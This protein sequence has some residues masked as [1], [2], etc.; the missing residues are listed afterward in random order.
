MANKSTETHELKA[1]FVPVEF[2]RTLGA[3]LRPPMSEGWK[4]DDIDGQLLSLHR[5]EDTLL[6][7]V[8]F[9]PGSD[10]LRAFD[11]ARPRGILG[12]EVTV[13][14]NVEATVEFAL[15]QRGSG[16]V[17]KPD[18]YF[19]RIV[20][21]NPEQF[22]NLSGAYQGEPW[23]LLSD[24]PGRQHVPAYGRTV[25]R[26][27]AGRGENV[28]FHCRATFVNRIQVFVEFFLH[29]Y[30]KKSAWLNK[31]KELVIELPNSLWIAQL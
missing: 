1:A 7:S 3:D 15:T 17:F 28:P 16:S 24:V 6:F 25:R 8:R 19:G 13:N 26:R 14:V 27:S 30:I 23:T 31:W 18:L 12:T 21:Q 2:K 29:V 5:A 20:R 4:D 22:C 10:V 9:T 11:R